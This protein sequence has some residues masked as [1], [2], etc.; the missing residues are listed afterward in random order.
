MWTKQGLIFTVEGDR[1]WNRSHAQCP[2]V[3]DG[4]PDIWRIYYA[5]RD[6]RGWSRAS[7]IDVAAGEP[8]KILYVHDRPIM[9]L[10]ELGAFDDTGVMPACVITHEGR[11]FLYY[12]GWTTR[13]TVPYSN[14]T[15][16]AES[17]DGGLTFAR[18]GGGPVI[19]PI[20]Q[21]PYFTGTAH[22]LKSGGRWQMWYLSCTGWH[23]F[24]DQTAPR[25]HIKYAESAD[26]I[27][28]ERN[29]TVALDYSNAEEGGIASVSVIKGAGTYRAWYCF[30]GIAGFRTDRT[31]TYRIGYAES[32]DG[33]AW[34]RRDDRAG[35]GLSDTGWDSEMIAY[36][37]VVKHAGTYFMFYN[38]N[39]FG[40]TGF[41]YAT[42]SEA[43]IER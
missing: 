42:A 30:R 40:E 18:L 9:D 29:G 32:Q 6:E 34:T 39:G 22:V 27:N 20:L 37:S 8:K 24:H 28:W 5:S 35:I 7:F 36:P 17:F 26:A 38:G 23:R 13:V 21:E 41:G 12:V 3:D 1:E 31:Q 19:P 33:I 25:Y 16:L 10:G 43:A 4:R 15:G 2:V 11:K 14:A